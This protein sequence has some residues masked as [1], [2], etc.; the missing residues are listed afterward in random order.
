M[1]HSQGQVGPEPLSWIKLGTQ[2]VKEKKG[3]VRESMRWHRSSVKAEMKVVDA[4]EDYL[5]NLGKQ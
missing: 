3:V 2:V 1:L 5:F 4:K